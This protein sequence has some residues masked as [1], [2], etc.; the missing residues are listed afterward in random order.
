MHF[1]R[2]QDYA[3]AVRYLTQAG[4]NALRRS[5]HPEAINLLTK[6]LELLM[7]L[8]ETPERAQHELALRIALGA[9]LLMTRGYAASEVEDTYA[10][11]RELCQQMGDSLQ[12]LPALAGLFRFYFVRAEFQTA[13][14]LAEQVLR[15]AQHASDHVVF[16]VAY[17]LLGVLFLCLGKFAAAREHLEKGIALYD[18]QQHRFMASLYGDDP[19]VTCHSF[20]A[21]V[22]WFL[23]YPD[24]ALKNVQKALAVAQELS[25]PYGQTFALD[26]HTWIHV[27][28]REE[29]AAQKCIEALMSIAAGQGFQF[30]L[31]DSM[32]LHGWILA[33]QGQKTEGFAQL[34]QGI[35]V[36]QAT[37]AKMSRPSHLAL[38]AKAYGKAGQ[39]EE[40]LA[41][42]AEA[43]AV[44]DK[45][46]EQS[47]KA[48]L[49]RL[50]GELLLRQF[51][52]TS[53][54]KAKSNAQKAKVKKG[55]RTED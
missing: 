6:G 19:G 32:V 55:L 29:S 36:Y 31:A 18:P 13:R 43:L 40:G 12:L 8:P 52:V 20:A 39:T 30:L 10:R 46:G 50:K 26:F 28:R 25:L 16:L 48:E 11:A 21:M 47:Y 15:L 45:T 3:R 44:A 49:Y 51:R 33:E 4:E 27:H 42:L 2:G 38:L 24:Q 17:S 41:A 1:E 53:S 35:A 54:K 7:T 9:P 22:L 5:A 34:H 37:G 14:A 23:G